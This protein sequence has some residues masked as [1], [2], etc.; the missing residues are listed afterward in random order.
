MK[1]CLCGSLAFSD[2]MLAI[3]G[4]LESYGHEVLM[5]NGVILDITKRPDFDP[6]AAKT[7]YGY[8]A[9]H[10]HFDKIKEADAV[11]ICNYDKKGIK[12][13]IG[14]NTFLEIGFAYYVDKKIYALHPLPDMPYIH[15]EIVSVGI[16]VIDGDLSKIG[17]DDC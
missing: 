14:A 2:E 1:I 17:T 15:D 10:G 9:I 3:Q 13:Y 11:L 12:N 16:R 5:P 8:D 7:Q 4:E 6:V